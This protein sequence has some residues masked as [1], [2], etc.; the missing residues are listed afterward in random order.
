MV[1]SLDIRVPAAIATLG[2]GYYLI[3]R[4]LCFRHLLLHAGARFLLVDETFELFSLQGIVI[5]LLR[6]SA[7]TG[8]KSRF[9]LDVRKLEP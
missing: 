3:K 1:N 4:A 9:D 6:S 8:K 2:L 5:R 7:L